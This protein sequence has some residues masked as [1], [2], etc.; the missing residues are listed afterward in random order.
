MRGARRGVRLSAGDPP[1][2]RLRQN[3]RAPDALLVMAAS[4]VEL[5]DKKSA[6][7]TLER[8]VNEYGQAPA[9]QTARERLEL[10][11]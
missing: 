7:A 11:R 8:I 5:N 1:G 2:G 9:A 6:R 4:Q 3:V 10:L